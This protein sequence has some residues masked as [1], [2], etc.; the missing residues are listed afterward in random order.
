MKGW[1]PQ[2]HDRPP[3]RG[4]SNR[5][6]SSTV[7]HCGL[8]QFSGNTQPRPQSDTPTA[9]NTRLRP[10]AVSPKASSFLFDSI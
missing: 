6:L 8:R 9:R 3:N 7:L 2:A 5:W 10:K 4:N 1:N